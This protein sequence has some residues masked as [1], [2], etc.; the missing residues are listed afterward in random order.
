MPRVLGIPKSVNALSVSLILRLMRTRNQQMP[1]AVYSLCFKAH[2]KSANAPS[3]AVLGPPRGL[4]GAPFGAARN[5]GMPRRSPLGCA[6][7]YA[8]STQRYGGL[9][10]PWDIILRYAAG[11]PRGRFLPVEIFKFPP[12]PLP[13]KNRYPGMALG[14]LGR[15]PGG[16]REPKGGCRGVC[17]GACRVYIYRAPGNN[18]GWFPGGMPRG[19]PR[20]YIRL[21]R[22][23]LDFLLPLT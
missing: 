10:R 17:R 1:L 3:G 16:G 15:A 9:G 8:A 6:A 4:P 19:M 18:S 14:A 5:P 12:P 13:A 23:H 7:G 21:P 22:L 20:G 2:K 11:V